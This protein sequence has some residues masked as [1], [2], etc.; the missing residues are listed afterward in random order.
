MTNTYPD[1]APMDVKTFEEL[2]CL[3]CVM[4]RL[5]T[6][7][8]PAGFADYQME[9][10][11]GSSEARAIARNLENKSGFAE[12]D[13]VE[14]LDPAQLK[15]KV[16]EQPSELPPIDERIEKY[17]SE[18][19]EDSGLSAGTMFRL[20]AG[21]HNNNTHVNGFGEVP[22]SVTSFVRCHVLI[23]TFP[24]WKSRLGELSAKYPHWKP[25]VDH[26]GELE[27]ILER[28][29]KR[30]DSQCP[31]LYERLQDLFVPESEP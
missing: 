22:T 29:S 28:E 9:K 19:V 8:D 6:S 5:L 11:S 21:K 1:D 14:I 12:S 27:T 16:R 13:Y 26:W 25:Y 2:R 30:P 4:E 23:E 18:W 3:R 20:F 15:A 10:F 17:Q 31:D 24:E 7:F